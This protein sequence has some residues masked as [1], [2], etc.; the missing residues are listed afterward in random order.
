MEGR[1]AIDRRE[2][3]MIAADK[4]EA[5]GRH[6]LYCQKSIGSAFG[7]AVILNLFAAT[8]SLAVI[9]GSPV[10]A[11]SPQQRAIAAITSGTAACTGVFIAADMVLTAAHCIHGPAD[12]IKVATGG[13]RQSSVPLDV[14]AVRVHEAYDQAQHND[15]ALIRVK[16]RQ[17]YAFAV[18]PVTRITTP[19]PGDSILALGYGR[20][21]RN[22]ASNQ[23]LYSKR[24][25][26]AGR[27][28]KDRAFFVDQRGGGICDGDS[29]GPAL[30][31]DKSGLALAGIASAVYSPAGIN[32]ICRGEADYT[33][34]R[35]YRSWI[36][37]TMTALRRKGAQAPAAASGKR[38][39]PS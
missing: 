26:V 3:D 24:L 1:S 20:T 5:A 29:G 39:T 4:I 16:P 21:A 32:D 11:G 19:L 2:A 27:R 12:T 15:L 35:A 17:G 7:L 37:K 31:E 8:P 36:E 25:T 9:G 30:V 13:S 10:A 33:D 28:D 23:N 6:V 22:A 14:I 38:G 34:V 18:N